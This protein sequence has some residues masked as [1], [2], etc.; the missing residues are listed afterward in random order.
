MNLWIET[1]LQIYFNIN[2]KKM[3]VGIMEGVNNLMQI[4]DAYLDDYI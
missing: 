2:Y 1:I 4:H 3:K